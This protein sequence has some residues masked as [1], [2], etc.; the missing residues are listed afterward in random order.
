MV[1]ISSNNLDCIL[2]FSREPVYFVLKQLNLWWCVATATHTLGEWFRH[3]STHLEGLPCS[4]QCSGHQGLVKNKTGQGPAP[5]NLTFGGREKKRVLSCSE[6]TAVK[7]EYMMPWGAVEGA[8]LDGPRPQGASVSEEVAFKLGSEWPNASSHAD[9]WKDTGV[10]GYRAWDDGSLG[11]RE[12]R[13]VAPVTCPLPLVGS[14]QRFFPCSWEDGDVFCSTWHYMQYPVIPHPL[15]LLYTTARTTSQAV[16]KPRGDL[17]LEFIHW[18]GYKAKNIYF[19]HQ[20]LNRLC[21]PEQ[22]AFL[23]GADSSACSCGVTQGLYLCL[24][25]PRSLHTEER[26]YLLLAPHE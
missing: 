9:L 11:I 4:W 26:A 1:D 17:A 5:P 12:Q 23:P 18:R 10:L 19:C 3:S 13:V 25:S 15:L 21:N 22:V 6:N 8:G 2:Y 7:Q 14:P 24:L 20:I 16:L